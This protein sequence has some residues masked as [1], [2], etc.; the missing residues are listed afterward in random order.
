MKT[1]TIINEPIYS[2]ILEQFD[3]L[4][5][6]RGYTEISPTSATSWFWRSTFTPSSS[7]LIFRTLR[8]ELN[9]PNGI[10]SCQPCI[11]I[12]DLSNVGDSWHLLLFHMI[13]FLRFDFTNLSEEIRALLEQVAATLE[14]NV[15]QFYFTVS[16]NG[17]LPE[18]T[19]SVCLGNNLLIDLGIP[20]EN[21]ILCKGSA[22]Y[23]NTSLITNNDDLAQMVGPKIELYVKFPDNSLKEIGTFEIAVTTLENR[24]NKNSFGFAVGLERL[25][26]VKAGL[27][28][29]N[30][31]PLHKQVTNLLCERLFDA[32]MAKSQ[33]GYDAMV[34]VVALLDGLAYVTPQFREN[35][36]LASKGLANHY[37]KIIKELT[38][39][40]KSFGI[41]LKDL[42]DLLVSYSTLD[43]ANLPTLFKLEEAK[44]EVID[45]DYLK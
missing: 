17:Y 33:L 29:I 32:T 10:Y 42:L 25:A 4:A 40:T 13:T 5:Q 19:T 38:R 12:S 30:E 16:D 14:I 35:K 8:D 31:L 39:I 22:N 45:V 28:N 6:Q 44:R 34:E 24:I 27:K 18:N 3:D 20:S 26:T 21:I 2:I 37:Q 23:Q 11:R 41:P 36:K 7:E 15:N 43:L 9:L 1:N